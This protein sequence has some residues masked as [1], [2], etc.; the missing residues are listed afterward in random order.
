VPERYKSRTFYQHNPNVT[1]MR[2]TAEENERMGRWIGERL[3][4]MEA[5]V[6][7][8][9]PEGGVSTLDAPGQPFHDPAADA[10]LFRVLEQTVRQT[11]LRQLIRLPHHINDPQFAAALV[12]AFRALHGNGRVRRKVGGR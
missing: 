2:T 8:L 12:E 11:S 9:L 7:F 4:R 3:N 1:L 5:A 6:R 10:A